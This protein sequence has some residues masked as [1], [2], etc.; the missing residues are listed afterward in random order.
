MTKKKIIII[1]NV[2]ED[3]KGIVVSCSHENGTDKLKFPLKDLKREISTNLPIWQ[4]K[5][6]KFIEEKYK[7]YP[8]QKDFFNQFKNK[9]I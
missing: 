6:K 2:E 3:G 4:I 1:D 5:L 7:D 8:E 9:E